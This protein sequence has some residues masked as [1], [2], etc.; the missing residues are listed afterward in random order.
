MSRLQGPARADRRSDATRATRALWICAGIAALW[1][2]GAAAAAPRRAPRTQAAG[3]TTPDSAAGLLRRGR[4]LVARG[5]YAEA[6]AVLDAALRETPDDPLVLNEL[7]VAL[8]EVGNLAR[9]EAVCRKAAEAEPPRVRASALYN[10]GRVLERRRDTAAALA[11]YRDSLQLRHTRIVRER[12]LALDPTATS[13]VTRTHPLEGPVPSIEQW[14]SQQGDECGPDGTETLVSLPDRDPWPEPDPPWRPGQHAPW[15][16]LRI[17]VSQRHGT[18][19]VLGLRTKRGWFVDRIPDCGAAHYTGRTVRV[20]LEDAIP[21]AGSH[22]LQL[23]L[24]SHD[25]Y[26]DWDPATRSSAYNEDVYGAAV[27]CGLGP[28]GVPHCTPSIELLSND[29][30]GGLAPR[31]AHGLLVLEPVAA[32]DWHDAAAEASPCRDGCDLPPRL[33]ELAGRHRVSFP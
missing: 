12:L 3:S 15:D 6:V 24:S 32:N 20:Q 14:C 18:E 22:E 23:R 28:S 21:S 5:R 19:C 9:A 10:L 4:A 7:G 16:E 11:A 2:P 27:I 31:W 29:G 25:P 17:V 1:L 26:R 30:R 13:E 33:R 8:R